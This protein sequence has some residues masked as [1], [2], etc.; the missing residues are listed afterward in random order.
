MLTRL[1]QKYK[2]ACDRCGKEHIR[3][4]GVMDDAVFRHITI[5]NEIKYLAKADVCAECYEE[6]CVFVENFF[7]EVNHET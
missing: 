1:A 7:D 2:I 5:S 6:L 4:E 3:E